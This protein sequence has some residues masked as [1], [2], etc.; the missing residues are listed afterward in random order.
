[1]RRKNPYHG[2][3]PG[4]EIDQWNLRNVGRALGELAID[5][6]VRGLETLPCLQ[7]VMNAVITHR[8]VKMEHVEVKRVLMVRRSCC[9]LP[10]PVE[11]LGEEHGMGFAI[12]IHLVAASAKKASKVYRYLGLQ[13]HLAKRGGESDYL[14]LYREA[15]SDW[16]EHGMRR[17]IFRH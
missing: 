3:D 12:L 16:Y 10:P 9:D 8:I 13:G 6:E 2:L 11:V 4:R 5:S 14:A 17:V 15:V 7:P 1:V